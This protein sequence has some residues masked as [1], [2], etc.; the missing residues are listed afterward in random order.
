M[1]WL[2][3]SME[4]ESRDVYRGRGPHFGGPLAFSSCLL[5]L[6]SVLAQRS[7]GNGLGGKSPRQAREDEKGK[8][9]VSNGCGVA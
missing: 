6:P 4:D 8:K 1:G 7:L 5:L 2:R 9:W 3:Q